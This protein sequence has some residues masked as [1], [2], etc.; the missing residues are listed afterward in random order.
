MPFEEVETAIDRLETSIRLFEAAL[1]RLELN[2][3]LLRLVPNLLQNLDDLIVHRS[4]ILPRS[5]IESAPMRT[6]IKNGR[7]VTAVDD[8]DADLLIEDGKIAMIAK[9]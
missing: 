3:R 1:E 5:T 2:I 9:S 7:I 6:I 4:P 8:Y